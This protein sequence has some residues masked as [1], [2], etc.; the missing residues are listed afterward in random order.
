MAAGSYRQI[1]GQKGTQA[2]LWTQFLGAFNDNVFKIAVS[3]IAVSAAAGS[4]SGYLTTVGAV[5]I[6]PFVLFSG[7]AGELSDRLSKRTILVAT[8]VFEIATMG[9]AV[10]A[11]AIGSLPALLSVLFLMAL[12]STF[13]SPAKYGIVPEL[14]PDKDLSRANGLLEMSTFVAIIVGTSAGSFMFS[15]WRDRLPLLGLV[16]LA[17]AVAGTISSLWIPRV[18]AAATAGPARLSPF[19]GIGSGIAR[20]R[21]DRTLWLSVI[22]MSYFWFFGALLQMAILLLGT[23]VMHLTEYWVGVLGAFLAVGIALGSMAAGRLSGDKVELGLVPLGSIGIGV[24]SL[25]LSRV[26]SFPAVCSLLAFLGLSG[27]LFVVPLNALLQ[28]KAGAAERGQLLATNS[29][30]NNV[31]ILLASGVLWMLRD[32]LQIKPPQILFLFG[33]VTLAANVYVLRVLPAF[34]IRFVLWLL[35]HTV[36]RIRIEGQE[37]VPFRGPALLVCNHVSHVDGFL[38]GACV[39]RF[40]RFMVYR[41]YYELKAFN[42]ILRL[43]HAI[44]VAAGRR[45]VAESL[46]RARE[47]LRQGHV[48]CI[49]AE[50]AISRTGNLLPFKRGFERIVEGLDVPVIPVHLDQVWGSIFS[51]KNGRFFWKFPTRIPYPVTVTFGRP[52]PSTAKAADVRQ[53]V[54][55]LG[56]EAVARRMEKAGQLHGRFIRAARRRFFSFAMADSLGRRLTYGQALI[57]S[58]VLA[59]KIRR[60]CGDDRMVGLML[61]ASVGGALANIG[62]ALAGKVPVNLNFTAGREAMASAVEQCGIRTVITSRMFLA[63]A[64]L[65]EPQGAWSLE[66]VMNDISALDKVVMTLAAVLLPSRVIQRLCGARGGGSDDLATVMFSSG[67]T[68]TPKGVMLSHRNILANIEGMRQVFWVTERDVLVGVLPFF[69]SFG[70]TGCI[71]LPLVSGFGVVYHANPMDAGVVGE[72]VQKHRAT[73][74]LSTPTFYAAYIRKCSAEQFAT[75]RYT[76]VGAEKLREP[77]ARTFREK[78]GLDLLE[79]YGCTEMAPVVSVNVPGCAPAG[80][81]GQKLGTASGIRCRAS[82]RRPSTRIRER[83]S[84]PGRKASSS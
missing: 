41:P 58:L 14:L 17:V 71:W 29:F 5:F 84:R 16:L 76:V 39:Q 35:T 68:G 43:M 51:F 82:P 73:M 57:A 12:Q 55:E 33:L 11:F 83:T 50:G 62:V 34:L 60:R 13:F 75:L 44:P 78:Y 27:G 40:I 80:Q 4:G 10:L 67:S 31:G 77:I 70:F 1:V 42:W 21:R 19:G 69:H 59:R 38:V 72:L 15:A 64:R 66:D 6:L 37:H 28:Q 49:F 32:R 46:Q 54:M 9:L 23:E 25:L 63:K 61:P 20:L 7:Y 30:L 53:A 48:V 52:L 26:E 56:A 18:P 65:D 45:D 24:S 3:L 36:Y 2:F 81:T 74:L 79:G 47:E 22:G 8:K